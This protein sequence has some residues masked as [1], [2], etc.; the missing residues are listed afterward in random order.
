M[1]GPPNLVDSADQLR[2]IDYCCNRFIFSSSAG[3]FVSIAD[4]QTLPF[5]WELAG[6]C[7]H[8]QLIYGPNVLNVVVHSAWQVLVLHAY[9]VFQ[10]FCLTFWCFYSYYI[11]SITIFSLI[12]I[13]AVATVLETI[14]FIRKAKGMVRFVR[15]VKIQMGD[16]LEER[17][18]QDLVPGDCVIPDG[19]IDL[20]PCDGLLLNDDVIKLV[21]WRKCARFQSAAFPGA[22]G[23]S[24]SRKL[25]AGLGREKVQDVCRK[26]ADS[27]APTEWRAGNVAGHAHRLSDLEALQ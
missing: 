24:H 7:A 23:Q 10:L 19:Q 26:A 27:L 22:A 16:R 21:D 17:S 15:S 25:S 2:S 1:R 8:Q 6:L 18:S 9:N 14:N 11:L 3:K 20:L 12:V 5:M 13:S 4:I